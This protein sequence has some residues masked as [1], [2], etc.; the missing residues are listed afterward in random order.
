M[1][2]LFLKDVSGVA[3]AGEIKDVKSGFA[4]N[5]LLPKTL[6][7]ATLSQ[8]AKNIDKIKKD[9]AKL[10]IAALKD[11][12]EL[13]SAIEGTEV[14][15]TAKVSPSGEYYGTIGPTQIS[16]GLSSTLERTIER[17]LIQLDEPIKT[18]GTYEID[19]RLHQGVHAK[20]SVIAQAEE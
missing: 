16:E 11:V 18:P 5:H 10:R 2:V 3:L 20:V 4:R 12:Q 13:A 1:R 19:L 9:A 7:T 15:L 6:A 14:T 8:H 17:H